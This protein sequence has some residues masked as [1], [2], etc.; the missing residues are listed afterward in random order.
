MTRFTLL[1]IFG[2]QYTRDGTLLEVVT[3]GF[4]TAGGGWCRYGGKLGD[5][6]AE[7][8]VIRWYRKRKRAAV[9]VER[10]ICPPRALWKHIISQ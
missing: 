2:K 7:F 3:K 6:P 10:I 5:T 9:P 4:N 1:D 8:A